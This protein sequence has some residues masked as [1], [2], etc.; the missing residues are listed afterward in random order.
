[1]S[2]DKPSMP[3]FGWRISLCKLTS[4]GSSHGIIPPGRSPVYP[5]VAA[6]RRS[7]SS[8][9]TFMRSPSNSVSTSAQP[10]YRQS[11][12]SKSYRVDDWTL[13]SG[14]PFERLP[15]GDLRSGGGLQP[16]G[17]SHGRDNGGSWASNGTVANVRYWWG[18]DF[19]A[20]IVHEERPKGLRKD[21]GECDLM[22]SLAP[23]F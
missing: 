18:V 17:V 13:P 8:A 23:S 20:N 22:R 11:M 15:L 19:G 1:M 7:S 12:I 9:W 10:P 4:F 6:D 21:G 3:S 5:P 16:Y 14:D 2:R